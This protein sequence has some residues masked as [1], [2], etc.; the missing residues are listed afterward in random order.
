MK[1][2]IPLLLLAASAQAQTYTDLLVGTNGAIYKP[3]PSVFWP[4]NENDAWT[5]WL[6]TNSGIPWHNGTNVTL[7][8]IGANLSLSA[9]GVLS[10]TGID[11]NEPLALAT[12][13]YVGGDLTVNGGAAFNSL[14]TPVLSVTSN[15]LGLT[16]NKMSL[17][18][19]PTNVVPG[20]TNQSDFNMAVDAVL[21]SIGLPSGYLLDTLVL[22]DGAWTNLGPH[23][24]FELANADFLQ[25]DTWDENFYFSSAG[26]GIRG[27]VDVYDGDPWTL[28][29]LF[30]QLGSSSQYGYDFMGS[31]DQDL[32][33]DNKCV[34]FNFD[35]FLC[36]TENDTTGSDY[37]NVFEIHNGLDNRI[38][39]S[40]G[41]DGVKWFWSYTNTLNFMCS[42]N[43]VRVW[44]E[45]GIPLYS[46]T[47]YM[48]TTVTDF[49]SLTAKLFF[50]T[51]AA[52][53][54][55]NLVAT[56]TNSLPL[57]SYTGLQMGINHWPQWYVPT[58]T[59]TV[60]FDYW[61]VYALRKE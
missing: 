25:S 21:G 60:Y 24:V 45:T 31:N 59:R 7:L 4:I 28:G 13:L 41:A 23:E 30:L 39:N 22:V 46:N 6:G 5:H 50:G 53:V 26:G 2:F 47:W 19:T 61:K 56:L 20:S 10:S 54:A 27:R 11:T 57:D 15:F 1:R 48:T 51:N 43:G 34:V 55:T 44:S 37:T 42:S 3:L 33:F 35:R 8:S 32:V 12:N 36:P 58:E 18:F 38:G 29:R 17:S 52:Q 40:Y 9:A 49:R 14:T 16:D